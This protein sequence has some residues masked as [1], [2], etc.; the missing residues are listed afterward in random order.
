[1]T[2]RTSLKN[3]DTV[4]SAGL[5]KHS[6]Y[7]WKMGGG[8]G[9]G[10]KNSAL[11]L[12]TSLNKGGYY[13]HTNVE[14]P[15]RVRLGNN[16]LEVRMSDQPVRS[17]TSEVN[18]L[19]A[20]DQTTVELW[21]DEIIKGGALLADLDR[22]DLSSYKARLKKKRIGIFNLPVDDLLAKVG[23]P[24]I[25]RNTV[26][27]G[28]IV[29]MICY[30]LDYLFV[31][32]EEIFGRKGV[33]IVEGNKKAA[34]AG[35]DF[36][37]KHFG[38]KYVCPVESKNKQQLLVEG[39]DA[40]MLGAIKAGMTSY[41]GYPMTPTSG[42]LRKGAALKD[43]KEIFVYQP[44]DEISA[45]EFAIGASHAGARAMTASSGGGFSL[46]VESL[47][48][49]VM[50]ETPLVVL[51]GQRPGP[52]TGLPTRTGQGD[53]RFA[54]HSGQDEPTR[55]VL[56]PGDPAEAF[57]L[58]FHAF[59]IAEKYQL[60][61]IILTDKYLLENSWT[62]EG[63]KDGGLKIDRGKLVTPVQAKKQ[64]SYLRHKF[65]ADGVSPRVLPGT[66]G[67]QNIWRTSSDEHNEGGF[68]DETIPNRLAMV[69]KRAN[70]LKSAYSGYIKKIK[71]V[72]LHGDSKSS[73]VV[74]SFGSNKGVLQDALE[75]YQDKPF[76]LVMLRCV[77]PFPELE[78]EQAI[79]GA[80]KIVV[81]EGNDS[82]LL[83][84]LIKQHSS[85]TISDRYRYFDGRPP[86]LPQITKFL[87]KHVK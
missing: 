42:L 43:E 30:E 85:A 82:G 45:I 24:P 81:V 19:A 23:Q 74:V 28:A 13:I 36:V 86:K 72:E 54:M 33:K 20:L 56:V 83:E 39:S 26:M 11:L 76:R 77:M 87:A 22:V 75:H 51:L 60:L 65:T 14:Y 66:P 80:K 55:V 32:L 40:I 34:E 69:E 7:T 35:Y 62:H 47:G 8:A 63:L 3:A 79:K 50:T 44:E 38:G 21:S 18:L 58:T 15:S 71:P 70:K 16:V 2:T 41:T 64:K 1:M 84:G 37:K 4:D 67:V 25:M 5:Q 68:V 78:F 46:M 9:T 52:S 29:G 73:T 17:L 10:I 48:L 27:L 6:E 31:G 59:N 49:A 53:L 61:V 12:A 57:E